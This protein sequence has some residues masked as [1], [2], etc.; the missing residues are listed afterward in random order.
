[1]P[2]LRSFLLSLAG[3]G[4]EDGKQSAAASS[5]YTPACRCCKRCGGGWRSLL[6]LATKVVA[7]S[8]VNGEPVASCS[9]RG[10]SP[11]RLIDGPLRHPTGLYGC[12]TAAP[13]CIDSLLALC[14]QVVHPR[15]YCCRPS[16]ESISVWR[17]RWKKDLIAFVFWSRVLSVKV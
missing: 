9:S 13:S 16:S 4:G 7:V 15:Q 17:R 6:E 10:S 8:A 11:R 3:C 1:M 5:S 2:R 14:P 12:R